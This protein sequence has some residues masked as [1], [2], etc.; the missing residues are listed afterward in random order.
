MIKEVLT[1]FPLAVDEQR[2]PG[3]YHLGFHSKDS[4]GGTPWLIVREQGG[5][6]VDSPRYSSKLA[7][8]ITTKLGGAPVYM[9]LTHEVRLIFFANHLNQLSYDHIA[10]SSQLSAATRSCTCAPA[11]V[12]TSCLAYLHLMMTVQTTQSDQ[13]LSYLHVS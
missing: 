6:M 11:H 12:R 8:A 4:Y 2:L 13:A 3:V 1:D 7:A 5:V 9:L 10:I